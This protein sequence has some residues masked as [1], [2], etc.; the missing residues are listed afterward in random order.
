MHHDAVH[1]HI[2]QILDE[3]PGANL[4]VAKDFG[5]KAWGLDSPDSD[6]DV[7]FVFTQRPF[8]YIKLGTYRQNI[9]RSFVGPDGI[10]HTVMG[11][12]VKRF[13]ELIN[14]SNPT[15]IEF[16]ASDMTYAVSDPV[17]KR[18]VRAL[19]DHVHDNFKPIAMMGHYHSMA[20]RMW[21][22]YID[23]GNDPSLKRHLYIG[24]ALLYKRIV[25]ETHEVPPINF[26]TALSLAESL[27]GIGTT[28]TFSDVHLEQ[29]FDIVDKLRLWAESKRDGGGDIDIHPSTMHSWF[30]AE[31]EEPEITDEHDVRGIDRSV[32]NEFVKRVM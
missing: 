13:A 22:K 8:D 16:L 2:E 9:D 15:A 1:D 3:Y 25:A 23:S 24:R 5:S 32:V 21:N 7:G 26:E 10:E 20:K 11:W 18:A 30:E 12:N 17:R 14:N 27:D 6:H 31:L 4:V 28:H 29:E 19:T